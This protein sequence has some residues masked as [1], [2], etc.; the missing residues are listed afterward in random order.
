MKFQLKLVVLTLCLALSVQAFAQTNSP[1][2]KLDPP[3]TSAQIAAAM[4][5]DLHPSYFHRV[6]VGLD[7]MAG[8]LVGR[9]NDQTISSALEICSHHHKA[10]VPF[11]AKVTSSEK[12]VD[13]GLISITL[14]PLSIASGIKP[15]AG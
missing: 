7:H 1:T 2:S 4:T 12:A 8:A 9:Q 14:A 11:K 10:C 6:F 3:L 15:A 5:R 13:S